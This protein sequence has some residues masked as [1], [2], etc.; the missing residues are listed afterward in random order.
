V[1]GLGAGRVV[2][3]DYDAPSAFGYPAMDL[4]EGTRYPELRRQGSQVSIARTGRSPLLIEG[5]PAG[6]GILADNHFVGSRNEGWGAQ[7][8]RV[9]TGSFS[10]R[11]CVQ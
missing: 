11:L 7:D 5:R 9:D 4:L 3:E 2:V 1:D 8:R 6:A 10:R